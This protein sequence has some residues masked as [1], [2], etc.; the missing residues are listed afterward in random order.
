MPISDLNNDH[1]LDIVVANSATNNAGIFLEKDHG[2]NS[3]EILFANGSKPFSSSTMFST[4]FESLPWNVV[5]GDFNNN[6]QNDIAF[7]NYGKTNL[8]IL[9]EYDISVA[10][11]NTHNIGVLRGYCNGTFQKTTFYSTE[12]DSNSYSI[13]L[14]DLNNDNL[15]DI[16]VANNGSNSIGIFL[17]YSNGTFDK[18]K[19]Y[20]IPYNSRLVSIA[21]GNFNRDG[22]T[23]IVMANDHAD[24][25][26][27]FLKVC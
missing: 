19:L 21:L 8:G 13:A 15:I 10:N 14:G 23:G 11:N 2:T 20:A 9:L 7:T 3:I 6:H 1:I 22:W 27:I 16:S 26:E 12:A 18:Q 24:N 4:G 25:F 17:G 5:I